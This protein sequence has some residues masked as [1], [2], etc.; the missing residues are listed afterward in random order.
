MNARERLRKAILKKR[1]SVATAAKQLGVTR[2]YLYL[3]M[4][5]HSGKVPGLDFAD[6]LK[7]WA[8]IPPRLWDELVEPGPRNR[9][10][11]TA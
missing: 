10:R 2:Q 1:I 3:L 9:F 5:E 4:S 6:R 7:E 8:S 11:R